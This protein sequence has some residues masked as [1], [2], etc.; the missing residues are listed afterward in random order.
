MRWGLA[1]AALALALLGVGPGLSAQDAP[2]NG[3]DAR[4]GDK[5]DLSELSIE[6]LMQVEI[7]SASKKSE[8][9]LDTPAAVYVIRSEDILRSGATSIP[10]ALRMAPGMEVAHI[11]SNKW[12]ISARG[13]ND[14]FSNKLLVLMDGRSVYNP[15]FSGVYWDVQDL[16]LQDIDRIEVIR[17]PGGTI[18]GANAVDGVVNVISKSARDTQGGSVTIGGGTSE[19][20][21]SAARYGAKV[22]DDTYYRVYAKWFERDDSEPGHDG[23]QQ[24]RTG[25][26]LDWLPQGPTPSPSRETSIAATRERRT[27]RPAPIRPSPSTRSPGPSIREGISWDGGCTRSGPRMPSR[28]RATMTEQTARRPGSGNSAI[29]SIS[30]STTGSRWRRCMMSRWG[31]A[32]GG[33]RESSETRTPRA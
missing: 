13:F 18:W 19:Q 29:R 1:T 12:A 11:D 31:P 25:F 15:T 8:R 9:L 7:T 28:S 20:A 32:T 10:E 4:Q 24:G 3:D 23:W 16:Y 14:L 21:F 2:P 27:S 5:K 26:R 33:P 22:G 6:E 30:T 17:G